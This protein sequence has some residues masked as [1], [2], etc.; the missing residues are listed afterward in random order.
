VAS[1]VGRLVSNTPATKK[2]DVA[3][4]RL[5]ETFDPQTNRWTREPAS[6]DISLPLY[7]RLHLAHDG[8]VLYTGAGIMWSPFGQS[9]DEALWNL[10]QTYDPDRRE[11][12]VA[13]IGAFGARSDPFSVAL[14]MKPPYHRTRILVGGGSLGTSPSGY[15][16]TAL[17]EIV[18]YAHGQ[19]S[20]AR[21]GDL[22]NRRWFSSGVLLPDGDVLALAGGDKNANVGLGTDAPV[23]EVELFDAD[24]KRWRPL[25]SAARDRTYHN[26]ALLLPDGRV[27]LGGHAPQ[28]VNGDNHAPADAGLTASNLKDPSFEIFTPPYLDPARGPRPRI[29]SA[30]AGMSYRARSFRI[31]VAGDVSRVVL[32]RLPATTHVMDADQRGIELELE[33][34]GGRTLRVTPPPNA[35][36][37][38]PGYYYLF[39]V[40]RNGVPSKARVVRV[41]PSAGPGGVAP[42]PFGQ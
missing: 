30:R 18:T 2:G 37:A 26:T 7:P 5:V 1:G 10:H 36:V 28:Q 21:T 33:R 4:V 19:T 32:M 12:T 41:G 16:G 22:N 27:L 35:R 15:L 38:P 9:P 31:Q 17:S 24:T 13:G 8:K 42:A 11:W 29:T 40:S 20:S 39:A 14:M 23:R 34:A 3:N 25:A 6:A